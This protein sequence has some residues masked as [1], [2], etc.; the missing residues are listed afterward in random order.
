M[1]DEKAAAEAQAAAQDRATAAREPA[2]MEAFA[3]ELVKRMPSDAIVFDEA[4]TA[5]LPFNRAIPRTE[6]GSYFFTRG[7]SLGVGFPGAVGAQMASPE[8]LVVGLCGDGGTMY[9]LQVL[10]TAKKYHSKTLFVVCNNL[11]YK[12]LDLNISHYWEEQGIPPHPFPAS[13][14]LSE[15]RLGFVEMAAGM[16]VPGVRIERADEIPAAVE[17]ALAAEGPF[18]IDL[19]LLDDTGDHRPGRRHGQ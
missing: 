10:W 1:R 14:D 15:P 16:G 2:T 7:G 13:F 6:P 5:S 3:A 18:L 11:R 12:L 9:T 19:M 4:L 17:R 8:K